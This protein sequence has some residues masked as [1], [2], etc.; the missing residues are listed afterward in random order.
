[1]KGSCCSFRNSTSFFSGLGDIEAIELR[2]SLTRLNSKG[3]GW[4]YEYNDAAVKCW[5]DKVQSNKF[6]YLTD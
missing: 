5:R 2:D 1:M 3:I 4:E 6:G